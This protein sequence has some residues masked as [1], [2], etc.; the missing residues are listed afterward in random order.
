MHQFQ[1][2]NTQIYH[3]ICNRWGGTRILLVSSLS[4]LT[5]TEL[6]LI[7]TSC[8]SA[9]F[10]NLVSF[11]TSNGTN[12]CKGRSINVVFPL[13]YTLTT[14]P[15]I[16]LSF[17]GYQFFHLAFLPEISL[18]TVIFYQDHISQDQTTEIFIFS[19]TMSIQMVL[20]Q[21]N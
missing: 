17:T 9:S 2:K 21:L 16:L 8:F 3:L 18:H 10:C 15:R 5:S 1:L 6:S 19:S 20:M 4:Q 13:L 7:S 14:A 11:C 12:R